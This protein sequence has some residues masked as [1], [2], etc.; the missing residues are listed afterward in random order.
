MFKEVALSESIIIE[1][2][3]E[4]RRELPKIG[5]KKLY[6]MLSDKIHQ[7]AKIGRDKF[8]MILNNND[9]LIQRKRSYTRTT[10]SNHSFRKWTNLV[11]DV[12]VSAKNQV[13]VS[14]ITYIRTLEGFRYLS[15]ITDLYS[16]RIVGYCLSNSLSIEGC[17]E[18]LKKALKGKKRSESLI[19]HSDRGVQYCCKEYIL[20]LQK[21]HI[22]ISMTQ[23]NHCYENAHAERINGILKQEFNLGVTFNTEQQALSA[24]CSAIKTYNQKRPHYA[25]NLKTPDQVYFQKVA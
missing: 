15:L 9:L 19:H 2:V 13:W 8:F 11:K 10:Y 21:E 18:A 23:E 5:G 12:E 1:M 4:I 7:V 20:L 24:V 6:Y 16:R 25:L 14:D 22:Q 3:Q 17:L